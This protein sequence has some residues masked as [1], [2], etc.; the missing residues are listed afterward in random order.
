MKNLQ[1]ENPVDA[2]L[3][4]VKTD[5]TNTSLEISTE[6]IRI[7][8]NL[9]VVGTIDSGSDV[10]VGNDI[11]VGRNANL[12]ATRSLFFDGGTDTYIHESSAD[13]LKITVGDVDMFTMIE[14]GL[15]GIETKVGS[16]ITFVQSTTTYGA[17]NTSV[18]FHLTTQKSYLVFDGGDIVNLKL[19]FPAN[20]GNFVLLIKQDATGSRTITNYL[21]FEVE[22]SAAAGSSTV[23][24]AGGSNPD[25][26]DDANHV[27]IL[28]FY[29]DAEHEIAYGVATLDFQF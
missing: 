5:E 9:E 29:W 18:S 15:G 2:H 6:K 13:T 25:L 20:S 11:T 17:T 16:P 23:K 24:F 10:T 26:T 28:S 27:D 19:Y 12:A 14:G 3:K 8:D 22:G 21:A 4:P 7:S 1:L